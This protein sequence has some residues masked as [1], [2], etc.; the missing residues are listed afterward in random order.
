MATIII[1]L[2]FGGY[3]P[4]FLLFIIFVTLNRQQRETMELL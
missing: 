4:L 2:K 3:M 1:I